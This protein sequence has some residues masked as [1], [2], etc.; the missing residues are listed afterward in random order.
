MFT[1][2]IATGTL[3]KKEKDSKILHIKP[4]LHDKICDH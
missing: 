3:I 2:T 4:K 1:A